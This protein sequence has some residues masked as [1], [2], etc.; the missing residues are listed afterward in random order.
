MLKMTILLFTAHT[1]ECTLDVL[2]VKGM[3]Y[4]TI[5]HNVLPNYPQSV[6]IGVKWIVKK[7]PKGGPYPSVCIKN[8]VDHIRNH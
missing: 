8:F 1:R 7:A 3:V 2:T 6:F 5:I 4:I